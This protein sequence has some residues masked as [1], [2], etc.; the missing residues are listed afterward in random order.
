MA[1]IVQSFFRIVLAKRIFHFR[2]GWQIY[3]R[4]F[5]YAAIQIQKMMRSYLARRFYEAKFR[6]FL[7]KRIDIPAAV[8]IQR[9]LRGRVGRKKAARKKLELEKCI[10]I[11]MYVRKFV[12]R[13]WALEVRNIIVMN[14]C[15]QQFL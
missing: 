15:Y 12:R 14:S 6:A 4:S 11:Q 9:I 3:T 8:R 5:V 7:I 1:T 2:K 13:V 10:V